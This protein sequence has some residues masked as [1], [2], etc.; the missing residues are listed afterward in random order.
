MW[1]QDA[2]YDVVVVLGHNDQPRLKGAGS[3]IFLHIVRDDFKPT[4][5][6]IALRRADLCRL[7]PHLT[8]KTKIVIG[9][10]NRPSTKKDPD[11]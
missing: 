5:G 6:C 1:R 9:S 10:P 4:E 7:L 2:L 8:R 3:A 11:H